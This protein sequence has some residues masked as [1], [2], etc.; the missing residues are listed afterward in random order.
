MK[1]SI[2]ARLIV[3]FSLIVILP[4]LS[5]GFF[6]SYLF[7]QIFE[8][9]MMSS[10]KKETVQVDNLLTTTLKDIDENIT[11]LASMPIT[12]KADYSISHFYDRKTDS[13]VDQKNAPGVEGELFREFERYA[14]S[15]PGVRYVYMGTI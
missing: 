10:M 9:M 3:I 12:Q 7:H 15:H 11:Y 6:S 5:L 4:V 13:I 2:K 8:S 1:R 14:N